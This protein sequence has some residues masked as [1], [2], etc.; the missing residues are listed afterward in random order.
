MSPLNG[1]N[2]RE[3]T[4]CSLGARFKELP[5]LGIGFNE[6]HKFQKPDC[7]SLNIVVLEILQVKG[8]LT[9]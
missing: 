6:T 4:P 5:T 7:A 2:V 9:P 3:P 1:F 8:Q